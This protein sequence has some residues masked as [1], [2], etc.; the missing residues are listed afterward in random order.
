MPATD[1]PNGTLTFKSI[2]RGN[3]AKPQVLTTPNWASS[4]HLISLQ[5]SDYAQ[6]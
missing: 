5:F 6:D 3:A 1:P 2:P 4:T